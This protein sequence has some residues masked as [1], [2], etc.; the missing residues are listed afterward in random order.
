MAYNCKHVAALLL[1]ISSGPAMEQLPLIAMPASAARTP[2]PTRPKTPKKSVPDPWQR[3]L[4]SLLH[5]QAAPR[6]T[7]FNAGITAA[8]TPTVQL[9]VELDLQETAPGRTWSQRGLNDPC[10]GQSAPAISLPARPVK[11]NRWS[12]RAWLALAGH[13]VGIAV[14]HPVAGLPGID[15]RGAVGLG[16]GAVGVI[17]GS[18]RSKKPGRG[19]A[20][21]PPGLE[22][23]LLEQLPPPAQGRV[24]APRQSVAAHWS[25]RAGRRSQLGL[26][27]PPD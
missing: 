13:T 10:E 6:H 20:P 3:Q 1:E 25:V 23:E 8:A 11:L 7:A 22:R 19:P 18:W 24:R 27:P 16:R 26:A 17:R 4:H 12:D 2:S 21:R 9:G 5:P 15:R 14:K